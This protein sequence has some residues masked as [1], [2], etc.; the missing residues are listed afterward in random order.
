MVNTRSAIESLYRDTADIYTIQKV[1]NPETH[2]T[3]MSYQAFQTGIPCK[4]SIKTAYITADT[5]TVSTSEQSITLFLSPDI[6]VPSGSRF[7]IMH[8]GREL[9]FEQSGL[10]AVYPDH[11]EIRLLYSEWA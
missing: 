8:F 6:I 2:I 7:I 11:Q 4:L 3:E 10:P 5:D 9:R 1:V